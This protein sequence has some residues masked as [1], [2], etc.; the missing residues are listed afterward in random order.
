MHAHAPIIAAKNFKLLTVEFT[1]STNGKGTFS[2]FLLCRFGQY[3]L[4]SQFRYKKHHHTWLPFLTN[5]TLA[6]LS[7]SVIWVARDIH[8]LVQGTVH[9]DI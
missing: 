5:P 6:L 9:K 2:S 1:M 7:L 4:Y 8:V 3:I